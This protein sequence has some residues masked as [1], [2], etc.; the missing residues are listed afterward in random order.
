MSFNLFNLLAWGLVAF[1]AFFLIHAL[2]AIR[3]TRARGEK[4]E[5]DWWRPVALFAGQ[6]GVGAYY[7]LDGR[8]VVAGI[9]WASAVVLMLLSMARKRVP[10]SPKS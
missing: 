2:L 9:V 3:A 10:P 6:M 5:P 4:L 7:I 1:S 8:G